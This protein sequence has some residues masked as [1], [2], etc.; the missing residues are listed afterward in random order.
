MIKRSDNIVCDLHRAQEDKER[1]FFLFDL[2][3]KVVGFFGLNLKTDSSDL[4]I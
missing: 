2:K 1:E 4:L 3:T